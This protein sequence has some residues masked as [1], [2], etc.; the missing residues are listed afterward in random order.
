MEE[1]FRPCFAAGG[2]TSES[3]KAALCHFWSTDEYSPYFEATQQLIWRML[4]SPFASKHPFVVFVC[5]FV[6]PEYRAIFK[7]Q[8][9]I[10][11][12]LPLLDI[13]PDDKIALERWKDQFAKLN[14]W[15]QVEF[16]TIVYLDSDA[17]PLANINDIFDI[18]Q[19]RSCVSTNLEDVDED[20]TMDCKYAFAGVSMPINGVDLVNGGLLVLNPD[21]KHFQRLLRNARRVTEY[22]TSTMEQSFLNSKLAFGKDGPFP[23]QELPYDYNA[24][25][26]KYPEIEAST[27]DPSTIRVLHEKLW[28]HQLGINTSPKTV[29]W[30]D[31]WLIDWMHMIRFYNDPLWEEMR[32]AGRKP[33]DEQ[34]RIAWMTKV[35]L[36]PYAY[37][38]DWWAG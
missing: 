2:K 18:I 29:I 4:W 5:P 36:P 26:N 13:L 21:P 12:E 14:L 11:R 17:F 15:N 20:F 1:Y 31:R 35:G 16:K 6:G 9:A 24:G 37:A 19:E 3:E 27:L 23:A 30:K 33:K 7:G 10:V 28:I 22:D 25:A 34:E 8:G 32:K 38:Q